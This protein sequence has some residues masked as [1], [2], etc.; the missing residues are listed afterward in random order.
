VGAGESGAAAA[1]RHY[2]LDPAGNDTNDGLSPE[3]PWKSLAKIKEHGPFRPAPSPFP[4]APSGRDWHTVHDAEWTH[5][6]VMVGWT[7]ST[8]E[9]APHY[10]EAWYLPDN[11][12]GLL[13]DAW[14]TIWRAYP[15][16][17]D[18]AS[19]T[20]TVATESLRH[21]GPK[22]GED[23]TYRWAGQKLEI[24]GPSGWQ[25]IT[26]A[27]NT[28]STIT[29]TEA[30][31]FDPVVRAPGTGEITERR[32]LRRHYSTVLPGS[33]VS[34]LRIEGNWF[35]ERQSVTTSPCRNFSGRTIYVSD[36]TAWHRRTVL[37]NTLDT[38][39]LSDP[40]GFDPVGRLWHAHFEKC[41]VYQ[42]RDVPNAPWAPGA[43]RKAH[44]LRI[45]AGMEGGYSATRVR[46]RGDQRPTSFTKAPRAGPLSWPGALQQNDELY[47][48]L[49]VRY[50][51][52]GTR[53]FKLY[54][55]PRWPPTAD[56]GRCVAIKTI[57]GYTAPSPEDPA[58][59]LAHIPMIPFG[60][61][62]FA[63]QVFG[64]QFDPRAP[65]PGPLRP[66]QSRNYPGDDEPWRARRLATVDVL[67]E[68]WHRIE[69]YVRG[70]TRDATSARNDGLA[71]MWVDGIQVAEGNI[72]LYTVGMQDLRMNEID[73]NPI[74][75]GAQIG[76]PHDMF[77]DYGRLKIMAR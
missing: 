50:R 66:S 11:G 41:D 12:S 35:R 7:P 62:V 46:M 10:G 52:D 65:N 59:N 44:A 31:K 51:G 57:Y 77:V 1:G 2:H 14:N 28:A 68:Q 53:P 47:I 40:L 71:R 32:Q 30:L 43:T 70:N 61:D 17:Y 19:K 64:T 25:W 55:G 72:I 6:A 48:G 23:T 74:W 16:A 18:P 3:R 20:L 45:P 60:S 63:E 21:P 38:I 9:A 4:N 13:V 33:T 5:E 76:V 29:I 37:S 36:G 42:F 73:L 75:G 67:D 49:W 69:V 58:L 8:P 26:V 34:C 24:Q 56:P 15:T 22:P 39:T 27:S 54:M